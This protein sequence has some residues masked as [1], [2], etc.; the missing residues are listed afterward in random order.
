MKKLNKILFALML[1]LVGGGISCV[2]DIKDV[3]A[4][5]LTVSE[6]QF[7]FTSEGGSQSFTV[8]ANC[9]WTVNNSDPDWV[10]ID[11]TEGYGNG[12]ITF[13]VPET[14]VKR[15][16]TISFTLIS[17]DYGR[18][19]KAEQM[20]T[21]TQ[22]PGDSTDPDD[23]DT[24]G[25]GSKEQPYTV[26]QAL[27]LYNSNS[28]PSELVWVKGVIKGSCNT[29]VSNSFD[30]SFT[31]E[32]GASA[33]VA[34]NLVIGNSDGQ[35]MPVQLVSG[36]TPR[37]AL[38]LVDHPENLGQTLAVQGHITAYFGRG[39][40]KDT[41]DYVLGDGDDTGDGGDDTPSEATATIAEIL[42]LS[43]NAKIAD[44]T[45][46]EGVV[47]SNLA[48]N[49][50]TSKKGLYV[51]DETGGIQFFLAA[52]H[53]FAFGTR[54]SID[55][56]GETRGEYNGA[57]QV[58][59]TALSKIK[60]VKEGETVTPITIKANE[61]ED[62]YGRY[63]AIDNVQVKDSDLSNTFVM[64]GSHTSINVETST[65]KEFV[66]FSS[67]YSTYGSEKVPQGSGTLKGIASVNNGVLQLIFAQ[68]SDY[69]GLTGARFTASAGTTETVG[70]GSPSNPFTAAD[71]LALYTNG[72][73][74]EKVWVSGT[75]V[76]YYEGTEFKAVNAAA[77]T[78]AKA[79]AFVRSYAALTEA[80]SIKNNIVI[81]DDKDNKVL[82]ELPEG[83][84]R[85]KLNLND[86]P[87][88]A[89]KTVYVKGNIAE[90]A[91]KS[92]GVV[93]V[94][95][96]KIDDDG[97]STDD[98]TK[99]EPDLTGAVAGAVVSF[100]AADYA[101]VWDDY[102]SSSSGHLLLEE[103]L[104]ANGVG[105]TAF[106]TGTGSTKPAWF[107]N[108]SFRIYKGNNFTVKAGLA[109]AKIEITF[110]GSSY[111][112]TFS[113]STGSGTL[114][115]STYTWTPKEG[116]EVTSVVFTNP[117]TGTNARISEIKVT[118]AGGE[119]EQPEEPTTQPTTIADLIKIATDNGS[120]AKV[121]DSDVTYTFTGVIVSDLANGNGGSNGTIFVMDK[122]ATN[123]IALYDAPNKFAGISY[124]AGTVVNV[125]L[126]A[127]AA[128]AG[129][130]NKLPQLQWD[131][132]ASTTFAANLE[133]TKETVTI[134]PKEVTVS[135]LE[136]N[137]CLPVSIKNVTKKE[138]GTWVSGGKN[139]S[140]A[141][142]AE[143]GTAITVYVYSAAKFGAKESYA[144][145]TGTLTGI[146][147]T[148]NGVQILPRSEE[149]VADFM[150]EASTT[151]E[152]K[153]EGEGT[154]EKPYTGNDVQELYKNG[155]VGKDEAT[156]I[157][158]SGTIIGYYEG[159]TLKTEVAATASTRAY[160]FVRNYAAAEA[161]TIENNI[162]IE[163]A[164]G[165]QIP[166]YLPES[167][168]WRADLNLKDHPTYLKT[169]IAINGDITEFNDG[170][171][172]IHLSD[173]KYE[174]PEE[175]KEPEHEFDGNGEIDTPY[176]VA[177]V[178]YLY[179]NEKQPTTAVWVE[180]DIVGFY[181]GTQ[182][183]TGADGA[184]DTNVALGTA[185]EH[186]PVEL[187]GEAQE[188]LNLKDHPK[189]VGYTAAVQGKITNYL[190]VAGIKEVIAYAFEGPEPEAPKVEET[191]IAKLNEIAAKNSSATIISEDI[192]YTFTAVVVSDLANKNG[193]AAG[194][195]YVMSEDQ[196][197]GIALFDKAFE[198]ADYAAGTVLDVTLV[199][200]A[201][202]AYQ[203][204]GLN[205]ITWDSK[206]ETTFVDNIKKS[207]K[208]A[209][210]ITP[211][212]VS[213]S[214]LAN[215]LC[216]PVTVKNVTKKAGGT[217]VSGSKNTTH[218]FSVDGADV[219]V[220]VYKNAAF[221]NEVSYANTT[222][223]LTGIVSTYNG[224]Q[225]LPRN[226]E[227]VAAFMV[228]PVE[229][230][231]YPYEGKG[232]KEEPYSISDVHHLYSVDKLPTD[233]VWVKGQI[234]GYC[235][236]SNYTSY[237]ADVG[238]TN[239][240]IVIG[241]A[242]KATAEHDGGLPIQLPSN[243]DAR[244]NLN[245]ADHPENFN[246]VVS[247]YGNLE[248]YFG[249]DGIKNVADYEIITPGKAPEKSEP[250]GPSDEEILE[251]A[252]KGAVQSFAASDYSSWESGYDLTTERLYKDGVI[253]TFAKGTNNN[254]SPKW[255]NTSGTYTFR[256]YVNNT[257]TVKAGEPIEKIEVA[258][259]SGNTD[260][261]TASVES[262]SLSGT[263]Y[264]W[265]AT[266]ETVKE[267]T[268]TATKTSR[269][270]SMTVTLVGEGGGTTQPEPDPTPDPKPN[271]PT[272]TTL[273]IADYFTSVAS[274]DNE[275][276]QGQTKTF[277]DFEFSFIKGGSSATAYYASD[278]TLRFY[279]SEKMKIDGKGKKISKIVIKASGSSYVKT[280]TA[281]P[282]GNVALDTSALTITWTGDV[283][284]DAVTLTASAQIRF[285]TIDITWTE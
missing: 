89:G 156:D 62:Y 55:L 238:T 75:I 6:T 178:I 56:S 158:V 138:G 260:T 126:V 240:N 94:T 82:V 8:E 277:G 224:V 257:F 83:A 141:F 207:D 185:D 101:D 274:G 173:A 244:T 108:A 195:I 48:L 197:S 145:T 3:V 199:A 134:T 265:S 222:G 155:Y 162:V 174:A 44:G 29:N 132:S 31:T 7:A 49:N 235:N 18:W 171:G 241:G 117:S 215:N 32:T 73:T 192:T 38:N 251:K 151:P 119:P 1:A 43:V 261:Y 167:S 154:V 231:T 129:L 264:T 284:A 230:D 51:Q 164:K 246:A 76:G 165:A 50:L 198:N 242:P 278:S 218:T 21:I 169:E 60:K 95:E 70:D 113:T 206:A 122:D 254:N 150:E 136:N 250:E 237:V 16:A 163:D 25:D 98:P 74:Q 172:G 17:S 130:Y 64:N 280:V 161:Y 262:G 219:T 68:T 140:H 226:S 110:T 256:T 14:T 227:D 245:L 22:Y 220:Y 87:T 100:K 210:T 217:W 253:W 67:G 45:V 63:V 121:I 72:E 52:N 148:F 201:A 184:V 166:V 168:K 125:T 269:I 139:T 79:Y 143:D 191:T 196:K 80:Y 66:I 149:D 144:N 187:T 248:A 92:A 157:W 4:P 203:Y 147:S 208:P 99:P 12:E 131:S 111:A 81:A 69:E 77:A 200:G 175:P 180:G 102:E 36:S 283:A 46:I 273:T 179:T 127:G 229:P 93:D 58:S 116:D 232:I 39:G 11:P 54:V 15:K 106:D 259:E 88:N 181:N 137:L 34:S 13:F 270:L 272:T 9:A 65:A 91:V 189:N 24:E 152:V 124:P 114:N 194:T 5:K 279:T 78:A 118:L 90:T 263:T 186:I 37:T 170:Q 53:E 275:T 247:V 282:A 239:S 115:G 190:A 35:L 221:G 107:R 268:F 59:G 266:T 160:N 236:G 213:V 42:A 2:D 20:V 47:V 84:D 276:L 40:V 188:V 249:A 258:F 123:G 182:F 146:V 61:I 233:K 183:T 97:G 228:E 193:G 285:K 28:A 109:I 57:P 71:V 234:T 211:K 135:D 104:N 204:N 267:V 142:T 223:D 177:D 133:D 216:L 86:N 26:A 176:S 33:T 103:M 225:I 243:S 271:T 205:E 153:T 281:D 255:Y 10:T 85:D 209:V 30:E 128:K 19:G 112:S 252:V 27:A 96:S 159:T 23:E 120:T 214:E 202:Q 212:E 41:A 105:V